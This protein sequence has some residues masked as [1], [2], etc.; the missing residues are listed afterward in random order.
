[1]GLFGSSRGTRWLAGSAVCLLAACGVAEAAGTP[2]PKPDR[3]SESR[4][5]Y[6]PVDALGFQ[7]IPARFQSTGAT[8]F[9]VNFV[10]DQHLLFTFN[11]RSLMPRLPDA[12]PLDDDRNIE[13]VLLELP[14]GKVLARTQWRTRDRDRYLWPLEHGRFLLRVR[15]KL[16]VI[17]PLRNFEKEGEAQAFRQQSFLDLTRPIG[18]LSV[19]PGGDLLGV[20][21]IPPRKPKLTGVKADAAALAA[22]VAGHTLP[23]TEADEASGQAP[24]QIHF[25]RLQTENG[26]LLA[27]N[28]GAIGA[29]NLITLSTT[30]DGYL[31]IK[32]ESAATWTFDFVSHTGKRLELSPYD[33]SC[34]PHAHWLSRS[35]FVAFGCHGSPDKQQLSYFNLKGEEPWLSILSG[36]HVSPSII[37]APVAGRFA[38]SRTLIASTIYDTENLTADDLTAQEISV[39]SNYDGHLLL[40]VLATPIQRAGQNFDLSADG[41]Q[42]AVLKGSN[43]EV[44]RLP[45]LNGKEEKALK[46]A[47]EQVPEHNDG[48]IRMGAVPI[49]SKRSEEVASQ[50]VGPAPTSSEAAPVAAA[51]SVAAAPAPL[52]AAEA[53]QSESHAAPTRAEGAPAAL[54]DQPQVGPR[55]APSLYTS[56]YPRHKGDPPASSPTAPEA[57]E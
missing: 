50:P 56:E 7:V 40:K 52:P 54:G 36:T 22:T 32:Q 24:V 34:V 33:T 3:K 11:K 35:D 8:M 46:L 42:F 41:M 23:V 51:G 43:L 19:S 53:V 1:M 44:H 12:D 37:S 45:G 31:D 38:L 5:L 2:A 14:T 17:D 27:R 26:R 47:E 10:D 39:L 21:T 13:A 6:I 16:S 15:S 30:G 28:A 29:P 48:T 9:T 20:E 55:K 49:S 57:P 4:I 25:F 18:Y